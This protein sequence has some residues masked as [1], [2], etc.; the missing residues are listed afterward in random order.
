VIK[1]ANTI[2]FVFCVQVNV[3]Q[4]D[5]TWANEAEM[6]GMNELIS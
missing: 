4:K 5:K 2:Y 6:N 1:R 3:E